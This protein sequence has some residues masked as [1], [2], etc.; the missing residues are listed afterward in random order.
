MLLLLSP[1][2]AKRPFPLTTNSQNGHH[3]TLWMESNK[4]TE[5]SIRGPYPSTTATKNF[6][7]KLEN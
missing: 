7:S 2:L 3:P 1:Y 4:K 6:I 5:K